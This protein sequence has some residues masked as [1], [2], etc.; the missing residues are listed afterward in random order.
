MNYLAHAVLSFEHPDILTGNMISDFVKGNLQYQYSTSIQKGIRLHR[1][2]DAF[3]DQHPAIR[4]AKLLLKPGAGGYAGPFIDIVLDHFLCKDVS[5]T[6][7]EGWHK[8]ANDVYAHLETQ[9]M[10]LPDRFAAMLPYM[11]QHNWLANYQFIHA[12]ERS[13]HGIARRAKYLEDATPAFQLF[14]KEYDALQTIYNRFFP[15]LKAY[16]FA[17][18]QEL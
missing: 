17:K 1:A 12:I 5:E 13:F 10:L 8:F 9:S 6:P 4:E 18:M 15:E 11:I 14:E 2:I 3:T 16:S 7:E